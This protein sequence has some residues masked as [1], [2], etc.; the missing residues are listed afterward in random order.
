[1]LISKYSLIFSFLLLF[2]SLLASSRGLCSYIFIFSLIVSDLIRSSLLTIDLFSASDHSLIFFKLPLP[3]LIPWLTSRLS[4]FFTF[5]FLC[6]SGMS[7]VSSTLFSS[8]ISLSLCLGTSSLT[9]SVFVYVFFFLFSVENFLLRW[10]ERFWK[11][12]QIALKLTDYL[13]K[14]C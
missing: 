5:T 4:M 6:L 7:S 10:L 1:M 11:K 14:I 3:S 2:L 12:L 8:S 9:V 13:N